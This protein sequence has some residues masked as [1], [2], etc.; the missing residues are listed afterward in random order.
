ENIVETL[1]ELDPSDSHVIP[2]L[3]TSWEQIN[4]TTWRFHLRKGVTFHDGEPFN[5][6][7]AAWGIWRSMEKGTELVCTVRSRYFVGLEMKAEPV[8]EYTLDLITNKPAPI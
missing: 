7:T 4:D 5:A 1:T 8:D 6:E 3:A 2:R